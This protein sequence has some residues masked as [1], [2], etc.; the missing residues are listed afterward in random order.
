[1]LK[2]NSGFSNSHQIF[3]TIFLKPQIGEFLQVLLEENVW[4]IQKLPNYIAVEI[5]MAKACK[6]T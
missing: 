2:N 3:F 5:S 1:M 4:A 6:A